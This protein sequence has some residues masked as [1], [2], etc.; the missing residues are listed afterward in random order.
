M[1]ETAQYSAI[2]K[3]A[4]MRETL[5]ILARVL[6]VALILVFMAGSFIRFPFP[7]PSVEWISVEINAL[8]LGTGVWATLA[9]RR[10]N[11]RRVRL[12]FL[13]IVAVAVLVPATDALAWVQPRLAAV[14]H[15]PIST[16][17]GYLF[18]VLVI[19]DILVDER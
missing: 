6:C 5:N 17:F 12:L 4:A 15:H 8:Y 18:A 9:Y 7:V 13:S 1:G 2:D 16:A 14:L 3:K 19:V 11:S 10:T